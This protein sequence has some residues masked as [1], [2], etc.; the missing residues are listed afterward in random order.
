MSRF[1]M[2]HG[3]VGVIKPTYRPGSLEEFIRL[4][5]E[6]IGVIPLF[7][8]IRRGTL[9]EFRAALDAVEEKVALLAGIG[10]DLIHPEGAPPFMTLGPEGE[11]ARV[12]EWER[13]YGVPIVTAPQ[14]QAEAMRALG[15]GRIA[16]VT[17]FTGGI[18]ELFA[19]YFGEAGF[20][21]LA[22]SGIAVPFEGVGR[23]ASRDVFAHAVAEARRHERID[24]VYL[25]G[26]GWRILDILDPLE[27]ALGVPVLHAVAARVWAVQ[28]RLGV[29]VPCR[30][31][32]RLLRE[33][34]APA[35]LAA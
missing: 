27:A 5:P 1:E 13:R 12:A 2:E 9:D 17:Y 22:M 35:G 28:Q 20:D 7:L 30:G 6:G 15:M 19:R 26:S 31:Y 11:R 18:N 16:G 21:V 34:P 4:L 33:L 14:T 32:G 24:G 10:V 3:T 23:L 8:D 25:L 29:H